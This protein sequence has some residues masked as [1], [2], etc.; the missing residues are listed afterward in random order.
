MRWCVRDTATG[1]DHIEA[2]I[3]DRQYS[4]EWDTCA[5]NLALIARQKLARNNRLAGI[6]AFPPSLQKA[7][8]IFRSQS[9]P[10]EPGF[11]CSLKRGSRAN[12][13]N[14][15]EHGEQKI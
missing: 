15:T 14:M 12:P 3:R 2:P 8:L 1:Q 6:H 5:L 7:L 13:A 9:A 4:F 10:R 11:A